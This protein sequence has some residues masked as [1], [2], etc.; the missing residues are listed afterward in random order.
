MKSGNVYS[1]EE[2][3]EFSMAK[4]VDEQLNNSEPTLTVKTLLIH[5][6]CMTPLGHNYHMFQEKRVPVTVTQK[7][8]KLWI[9]YSII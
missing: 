4:Q 6:Q 9:I 2:L 8:K 3:F 5:S 7:L 1:L